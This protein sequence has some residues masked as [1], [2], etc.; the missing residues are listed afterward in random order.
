MQKLEKKFRE[1]IEAYQNEKQW[2][3]RMNLAKGIEN[4]KKEL[5]EWVKKFKLRETELKKDYLSKVDVLFA[6]LSTAASGI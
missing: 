4:I 2:T 1:T 5:K 3:L 6:T